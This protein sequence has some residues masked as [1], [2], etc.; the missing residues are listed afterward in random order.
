MTKTPVFIAGVGALAAALLAASVAPV[1]ADEHENSNGHVKHEMESREH[2]HISGRVQAVHGNAVTVVMPT[3]T[4]RTFVVTPP[5][6]TTIR[7]GENIVLFTNG[8]MVENVMPAVTTVQGTVVAVN[9]NTLMLQLPSGAIQAF[10]VTPD[11]ADELSSAIGSTVVLSTT[12]GFATPLT[13]G[14]VVLS[15][16]MGLPIIGTV[17]AING[18]MV[19]LLVPSGTVQTFAFTPAQIV[20]IRT[21]QRIAVFRSG[22]TVARV[23]PAVQ[24]VRGTIESVGK[25]TVTLRLPNGRTQTVKV[26]PTAAH[27]MMLREGRPV[28]VKTT[29]AFTTPVTIQPIRIP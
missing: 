21:G 14:N 3:G 15:P 20:Q 27:N 16:M 11:V 5:V 12:T 2:V 10:L 26:A 17:S 28:I 23:A 7:T 24:T 9:G 6:I 18:D 13:L 19:T 8:T 29:T 1:A 25:T 4:V 22:R